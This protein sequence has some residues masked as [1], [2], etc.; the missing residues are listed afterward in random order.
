M[1]DHRAEFD[2]TVAFSNGGSLRAEG[3][4]VGVPGPHVT[5]DEVAALFVPPSGC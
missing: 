4:R 5:E 1:T 3:F 2:A